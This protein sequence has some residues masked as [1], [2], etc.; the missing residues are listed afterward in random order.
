MLIKFA[1]VLQEQHWVKQKKWI[2]SRE[3]LELLGIS[4]N[5][6]QKLRDNQAI[7]VSKPPDIN[8]FFYGRDSILEYLDKHATHPK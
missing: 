7:R 3:A 8:K 5:T 6:L 2:D 4:K 1:S